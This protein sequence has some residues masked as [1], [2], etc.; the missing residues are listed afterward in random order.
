MVSPKLLK[1]HTL[2]DAVQFSVLPPLPSSPWTDPNAYT[3]AGN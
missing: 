2:A 1:G 3:L